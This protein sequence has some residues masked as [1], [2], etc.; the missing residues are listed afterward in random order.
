MPFS[1]SSWTMELKREPEGS[2]PTRSHRLAPSLLSAMVRVKTL[3]MLWIENGRCAPPASAVRPSQV[4]MAMAKFLGS[5][6]AS[7]G[8]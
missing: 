3:E 1:A 2:R 8:M 6:R 7:A 4:A 5:T